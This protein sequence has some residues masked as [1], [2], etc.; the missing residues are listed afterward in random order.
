M[1]TGKAIS[2]ITFKVVSVKI[3]L[4]YCILWFIICN[5]L[6]TVNLSSCFTAICLLKAIN[7]FKGYSV[8]LTLLLCFLNELCVFVRVCSILFLFFLKR[9]LLL[10]LT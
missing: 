7:C 8:R 9:I 2:S 5:A 1:L 10:Y 6:M 3:I 4:F